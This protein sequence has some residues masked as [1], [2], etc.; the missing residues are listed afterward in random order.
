[1]CDYLY[2]CYRYISI[3]EVI[4]KNLLRNRK[5]RNENNRNIYGSLCIENMYLIFE[6][7]NFF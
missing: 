2:F 4:F 5:K 1:M 3:N 7:M 6:V